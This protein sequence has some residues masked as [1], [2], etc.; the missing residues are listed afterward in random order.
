MTKIDEEADEEGG[1]KNRPPNK[2]R[3]LDSTSVLRYRN[4]RKQVEMLLAANIRRKV[5]EFKLRQKK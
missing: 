4:T 1:F 5:R 3:V 2:M